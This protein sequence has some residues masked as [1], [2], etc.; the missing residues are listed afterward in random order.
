MMQKDKLSLINLADVKEVDV[1]WLW[2]PYIPY[3]KIT[4][5]QGDPGEG[6]TTFILQLAALLSKGEM[7]PCSNKSCS[8][9]NI[10]Y[11]TAEDG[12][13]DTI[14]PRLVQAGADCSRILVIDESTESLSM[15]DER[16]EQEIA[17]TNARLVVLDP[18]QAYLGANV[19][20]YRSN[21]TRPILS[22]LAA[23]AERYGC[24]IVLIGHMNK[25][26]KTKSAYRGL[27]SIDF[28][29]TARSVLI[30]GRIKDKPNIRVIAQDKNSLAP[31]GTSVAFELDEQNGFR[32]LGQYDITVEELLAGANFESKVRKAELLLMEVLSDKAYTQKEIMQRAS[33]MD[34][35]KRSLDQ[36]KKNL[37]IS[38][39]K[40]AKQWW[41]I[42]NTM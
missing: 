2:Y 14:K 21:E 38:S 6:K 29:A 37:G 18:L 13:A 23:L 30:V 31:E 39:F 17:Q 4:I 33:E 27:G 26:S 24:A 20:M 34:I 36:A 19:D 41:W 22:Q 7:L 9:I 16:I 25:G 1:S 35:S 5:V 40:D 8:P 3:G 12:L 28:Q 15:Q 10:I 11:Q 32:W 42:K